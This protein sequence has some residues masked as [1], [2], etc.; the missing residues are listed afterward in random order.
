MKCPIMM[1]VYVSNQYQ[2]PVK[3]LH[4]Y[5]R[6]FHARPCAKSDAKIPEYN[7][8]NLFIYCALSASRVKLNVGSL[9]RYAI[10]CEIGI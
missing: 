8:R 5:T 4:E 3:C 6:S 1:R 9:V 7:A 2:D 10:V